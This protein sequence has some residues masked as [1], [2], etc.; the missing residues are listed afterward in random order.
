MMIRLHLCAAFLLAAAGY[1]HV[2]VCALFG[3]V[4]VLGRGPLRFAALLLM[5]L[6]WPYFFFDRIRN[7]MLALLLPGVAAFYSFSRRSVVSKSVVGVIV[8]WKARRS[9]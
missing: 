2:L 3:V 8:P 6:S 1:I 5:S 7:A 9:A 4:A